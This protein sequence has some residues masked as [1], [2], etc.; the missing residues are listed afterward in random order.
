M[1]R[2][3]DGLR[4]KQDEPA[5]S[6]IRNE[7]VIH[8]N[9]SAMKQTSAVELVTLVLL[10]KNGPNFSDS[11]NFLVFRELHTESLT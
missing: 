5:V 6:G 2:R 4:E 7:K 1:A 10:I 3:G 11:I 9:L 8:Q